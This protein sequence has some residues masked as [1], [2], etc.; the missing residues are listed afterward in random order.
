MITTKQNDDYAKGRPAFVWTLMDGYE[1]MEECRT[2]NGIE[3]GWIRPSALT[4]T[5]P[6]DE[7]GTLENWPGE[8]DG[9][10]HA[11]DADGQPLDWGLS[12]VCGSYEAAKAHVERSRSEDE[13]R[14][15]E[16]FSF[17]IS[18]K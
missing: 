3:I 17:H 12:R 14:P 13:M 7:W 10:P 1:P 16:P 8:W 18:T 6:L 15:E 2:A 11:T 5:T 4:K 9:V